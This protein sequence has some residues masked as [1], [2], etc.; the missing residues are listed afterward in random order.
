MQGSPPRTRDG[1]AGRQVTELGGS[2]GI[3]LR[4]LVCAPLARCRPQASTQKQPP[5][6]IMFTRELKTV[7]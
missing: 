2:E 4:L 7:E 3:S 6:F 5:I 1:H